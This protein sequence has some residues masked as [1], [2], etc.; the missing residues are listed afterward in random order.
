MV[1]NL[2][3]LM[4]VFLSVVAKAQKVAFHHA[5]D[6]WVK[7]LHPL[8]QQEKIG[9][10]FYKPSVGFLLKHTPELEANLTYDFLSTGS[11]VKLDQLF[12]NVTILNSTEKQQLNLPELTKTVNLQSTAPDYLFDLGYH[13]NHTGANDLALQV[14][15]KL[16]RLQPNYKNIA[17]ELGFAYNA[18]YK[19]ELA[20][21]VLKKAVGQQ[22]NSYGLYRE[23]GYAA[24]GLNKIQEAEKAYLKAISLSNDLQQMA[25]MAMYLTQAYYEEKNDTKFYQWLKITRMYG[26]KFDKIHTF[27]NQLET[28]YKNKL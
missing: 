8:N 14:L 4:L 22:T 16:Q 27:S 15:L 24:L 13:F 2:L 6:Q 23:L 11:Y 19:H 20:Y 21:A 25:E 26:D 5:L 1:R 9:Y 18:L 7:Y 12:P 28:T 10:I 3:V 17:F